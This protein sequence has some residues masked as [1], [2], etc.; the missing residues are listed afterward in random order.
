MSIQDVSFV[1]SEACNNRWQAMIEQ[2]FHN[3]KHEDIFFSSYENL[4]IWP[5]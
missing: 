3:M 1:T 5:K 2:D 4:L